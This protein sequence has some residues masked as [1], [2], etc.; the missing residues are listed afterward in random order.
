MI[1]LYCKKFGVTLCHD[2]T[3]L[4]KIAAGDTTDDELF[5]PIRIDNHD[6]GF[7]E[8]AEHV[9]VIRSGDGNMPHI[10]DRIC[11]HRKALRATL[12]SGTARKCRANPMVG[13][14]L[15]MVYGS[16]VLLSGLACLV[17]TGQ[18]ISTIDKHLKETHLNLQK[19]LQNTPRPVVHFLGGS[20]PGTGA[21]QGLGVKG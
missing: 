3:K 13:L 9:G 16:P 19:L 15:E 11:A 18:E 2:K 7:S 8:T 10:M 4:V 20:L 12:S 5:N 1:I 21:V 6:I 17:L 14:R